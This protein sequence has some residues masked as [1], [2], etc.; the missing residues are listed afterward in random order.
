M[1]LLCGVLYIASCGSDDEADP[2]GCELVTATYN[3]DVKAVINA[4]CAASGCHSGANANAAIPEDDK[5]YTTYAGIK[6][7]LDDGSFNTRAIIDKTM[8]PSPGELTAEQ[9]ELLTC[10]KD[11]GYPEN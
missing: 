4:S 3:G 1:F 6:A 10:W 2:T 9:L 5:D 7:S 8:P 11:A